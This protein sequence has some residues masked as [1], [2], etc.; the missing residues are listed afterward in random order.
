MPP[1]IAVDIFFGYVSGVLPQCA[2]ELKLFILANSLCWSLFVPKV[3]RFMEVF[4]GEQNVSKQIRL[5]TY[6]GVS[7]DLAYGGRGM[8]LLTAAGM[9]YLASVFDFLQLKHTNMVL[10]TVL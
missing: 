6:C 4:A 3:W 10:K 1:S 8:D 5:A 2:G 7:M 9:G